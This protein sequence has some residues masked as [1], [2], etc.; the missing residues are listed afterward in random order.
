MPQSRPPQSSVSW[1]FRTCRRGTIVGRGDRRCRASFASRC[2][3]SRWWAQQDETCCGGLAEYVTWRLADLGRV[4]GGI[5]VLP[6]AEVRAAGVTSPSAAR[7]ALG[8][9][10]AI[11]IGIVRT[12]SS[13]LVNVSLAD[14]EQVRELNGDRGT[15]SVPGYSPDDV[16]NLI[17]GLLGP[18]LADR[19]K[20]AW[21]S[22]TAS[23]SEAGVLLAQGLAKTTFQQGQTRLEQY[24]Q[25]RSL[26]QAIKFFNEAAAVSPNYAAAYAALGEARLRLFRLTRKPEDLELARQSVRRALDINDVLPGPWTTLGMILAQQGETVEAEKAFGQAIAR[27]PGGAD[28]Y[29][30]L[31]LAHQRARQGDKAESAYRKAI[32]LD[33]KSWSSHSYLGSFLYNSG[34]YPDAER[35]FRR[36]LEL[37]PGN[38]RLWSN[39]AGVYL[40]QERWSD[41]EQAL[42][43]SI[44]AYPNGP[45]LSNMGYLQYHVR[46]QYAE[47]AQTFQRAAEV[48]PRD[49]RIWKNLATARYWA[50]QR[51]GAMEAYR[52][53]A[54]LLDQLRAVDPTNPETLADLGDCYAM[55]GDGGRARTLLAEAGKNGPD[56]DVL[57]VM[58]GAY[59]ALGD[60]EEALR[61]LR[62]AL[63][64]GVGR[65]VFD[66]EPTF[67]TIEVRLA[68]RRDHEGSRGQVARRPPR[69]LPTEE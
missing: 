46:R 10:L 44:Q 53:A 45:A 19:E 67:E 32:E 29:R 25:A 55:L 52:Q 1:S 49:P 39:L 8:A 28:T 13:V 20:A 62:A 48:S 36:G 21:G 57:S 63:K 37:A 7:R 27:N 6:T 4:R 14:A 58:V 59:D 35:E 23:V 41:A 17:V 16:V 30:E 65:K 24:N 61:H 18:Q 43:S 64:A 40:A 33:P 38:A 31:G 51:D 5:A 3:R 9:T 54:A 47:A 12:G 34:R 68:L 60:R 11:S 42:A 2:C 69:C 50:G 15:F 22:A 26:E 66:E 56:G